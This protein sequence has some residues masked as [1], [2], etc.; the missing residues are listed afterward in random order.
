MEDT[1]RKTIK[2]L[3][4][5]KLEKYKDAGGHSIGYGHFIKPGEEHL[6]QGSITKD[7]AEELLT[8]DIEAHQAGMNKWLKRPMSE[9]KKAALTSLAYNLGAYSDGVKEVVNLYNQGKDAEAAKAFAK[10]NRSYNPETK[11]KEVNPVLVKRREFESR[12]FNSS[13]D[14]DVR[15]LYAEVNGSGKKGLSVASSGTYVRAGTVDVAMS[16]NKNVFAQLQELNLS[17]GAN[18]GADSE[19]MQRLRREGGGGGRV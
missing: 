16:E 19:F 14:V 5:L 9:A 13:D 12:L 4:G 6:M 11:T 15:R 1:T 10:Y 2:V 8:K 3:E 7:Q 17:L 18:L